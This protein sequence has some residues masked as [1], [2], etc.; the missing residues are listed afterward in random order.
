MRWRKWELEKK[1]KHHESSA[2]GTVTL[3]QK[4]FG[5]KI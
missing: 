4:R 3:E 5:R 1:I 2:T